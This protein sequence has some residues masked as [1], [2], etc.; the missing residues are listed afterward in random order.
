MSSAIDNIAKAYQSN[1][2]QKDVFSQYQYWDREMLST[3]FDSIFDKI[4][5][6][7]NF[8]NINQQIDIINRH[9]ANGRF[10]RLNVNNINDIPQEFWTKIND[11]SLLEINVNGKIMS[12]YEAKSI[13][14]KQN[15]F[16]IKN[17]LTTKIKQANMRAASG[18]FC[19]IDIDSI[20][21]L[22]INDL[23]LIN[24]QNGIEFRTRDGK[25]LSCNQLRQIFSHSSE[26][27]REL[28][29]NSMNIDDPILK[30]RNLYMELNKKV[31]YDQNYFRGD[32]NVKK[33]IY[34]PFTT[35]DNLNPNNTIICKGW[36]ELYA[37]LL[38]SSGF[39]PNDVKI[40]GNLHKWVELDLKNGYILT[41]DATDGINGQIDISACKTGMATNGFAI[42]NKQYSGT[43]LQNIYKSENKSQNINFINDQENWIRNIDK[44]LGYIGENGYLLDEINK[45]NNLFSNEKLYNK[46]FGE[47]QLSKNIDHIFNLELPKNV[48]GYEA[49]AFFKNYNRKLLGE[50]SKKITYNTLYLQTDSILEPVNVMRY[51][52][53][54]ELK[55]QLYSQSLG[56]INL[57]SIQELQ[58]Y[59]KQLN[60][61]R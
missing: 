4:N 7:A 58:F 25:I 46:L 45:S 54:N 31:H 39:D 57:N 22:D 35:F 44:S 37:D 14:L 52:N 18:N 2:I 51:I 38:I 9:A 13:N 47:K 32:Q 34:D 11:P 53:D 40:V 3:N 17:D 27:K 36:S 50:N 1:K 41:M 60:L 21:D 19:I 24:Y 48:D 6:S 5:S 10:Y 8:N 61:I 56:K 15:S 55:I 28:I 30:A 12:Y 33:A 26:L 43:R 16:N 42:L 59:I 49:Y 20:N 23:N 29:L